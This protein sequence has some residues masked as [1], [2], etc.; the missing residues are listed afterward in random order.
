MRNGSILKNDYFRKEL[1]HA[2]SFD[3][4]E[5]NWIFLDIS[6]AY[7]SGLLSARLKN[8]KIDKKLLSSNNPVRI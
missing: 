2:L 1:Q 7:T 3:F 5:I 6:P 8:I 4:N